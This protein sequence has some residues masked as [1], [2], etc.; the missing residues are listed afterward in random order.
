MKG[1]VASGFFWY[2]LLGVTYVEVGI[3]PKGDRKCLP[4][5][6]GC[7]A[8][9]FGQRDAPR[10]CR[11]MGNAYVAGCKLI[12]ADFFDDDICERDFRCFKNWEGFW[13]GFLQNW[14]VFEEWNICFVQ[15]QRKYRDACTFLNWMQMFSAISLEKAGLSFNIFWIEEVTKL[16]V[17][18]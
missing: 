14:P 15:N 7:Y 2:F 10:L 13:G 11:E 8:N 5:F 4:S 12:T 1:K 18:W 9:K 16:K 6:F 3:R 17:V